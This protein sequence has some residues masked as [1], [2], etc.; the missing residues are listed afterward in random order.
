MLR[1]IGESRLVT[2]VGAGGIGKTRLALEAAR[3]HVAHHRDGVWL[4][5]L[6]PL[7][8]PDLLHEVVLAAL[9]LGIPAG[10]TPEESLTVALA[11]REMLCVL[12]NCEHLI[13]ACARLAVALLEGCP[14][15]RI[16][17]TSREVLRVAGETT[18]RVSSMTLPDTAYP[19]R[20]EEIGRLEAV[21][22]FV[23]RAAAARPSFELTADN[24]A[25]VS[26][27]CR[28]LDGIPLAIELAAARTRTM[29]VSTID[30]RLE[31]RFQLLT[32]GDRTAQPRQRT[33][34]AALAWSHE[35]LTDTERRLFRRLSV[36]R[37]G[38]TL[39]AVARACADGEDPS[40]TARELDALAGL[41]DKSL[42]LAD[43]A[44]DRSTRYGLLET[45]REYAAL[46]LSESRESAHICSA[47]AD[48]Y[49]ALGGV[50]AKKLLGRDQ[51]AWFAR[52]E[53]ELPN[54]RAGFEWTLNNDPR[55]ALQLAVALE[56]YWYAT[57]VAEGWQW[58]TRALDAAPDRDELRCKGLYHAT[59]VAAVRGS[60]GEARRLGNECLALAQEIGSRLDL[61]L[62]LYALAVVADFERAD[63]WQ[64]EGRRL[65]EQAEPYLRGA[66]APDALSQFLNSF[67]YRLC[68]AGDG[69]AGR[70]KVE[71]AIAR[72]RASGD[73]FLLQNALDSLA[74]I[75]F[76][77]GETSSAVAHWN[78]SLQLV[79]ELGNRQIAA[80][81]LVRLAQVSLAE[82]QPSR[83]MR[84]LGSAAELQRLTGGPLTE[85]EQVQAITET[86]AAARKQLGDAGDRIWQE[87]AQMSLLE[88][89]R[90]GLGEPMEDESHARVTLPSAS[91]ALGDNVFIREGEFWSLVFAGR[92]VRLKDS[93]GVHDLARLLASPAR[94]IAAMDLVA[95]VPRSP[96]ALRGAQVLAGSGFVIEAGAGPLLDAEAREQYR[97]RLT[98]LE[99]ELADAEEAHDV[100]R[101]AQVREEREFLLTELS[102]AVGIGG[103]GR[104]ALDP[105]ERARKAVTGR[106]RDAIGRIEAVHGE[107]GRHLRRSVRTG[108]FCVYDPP[109]PTAWQL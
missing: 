20:P 50:V 80:I 96:A 19:A 22:L 72:D 53:A 98:D 9:G 62:A 102:A 25:C 2:L 104:P 78:E 18:W 47:H 70:S 89:V 31:D 100:E 69:A 30:E 17:A 65:F 11:E 15:L 41:I 101:A 51:A 13:D 88:A 44:T 71:E 84:L 26:R 27:I 14:M 79:G 86:T 93:K 38:F 10:R 7:T 76:E 48:F 1:L 67:G 60:I 16:L 66:D 42:V 57:S 90:Y 109:T 36:F 40:D 108:S 24:A 85:P 77:V 4:V 75:E 52:T 46:R 23:Q 6:A 92:A 94:E 103:R 37:G 58:W 61:G 55:R 29:S 91:P 39:D 95:V 12:D 5:E 8:T 97:E 83:C 43:E 73:T 21:Q 59:K 106:I 82:E 34:E 68:R 99:Q 63:G 33:L 45:I 54:L 56:R 64:A 49:C 3:H 81:V 32:G 28:R 87:G 107:L 105:A 74:V 35:L